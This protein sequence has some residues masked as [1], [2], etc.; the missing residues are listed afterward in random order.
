[1]KTVK[2]LVLLS[3]LMLFLT[4]NTYGWSRTEIQWLRG[5]I[6]FPSNDDT[7]K[8]S[9]I[10]LTGT[11]GGEGWGTFFFI[12]HASYNYDNKS[13]DNTEFVSKFWANYSLSALT[14][15]ELKFG[16][17]KDIR[18]VAGLKHAPEVDSVWFMPG[19]QLDLNLPGFSFAN[20]RIAGYQHISGGRLAAKHFTTLD[21]E[22][23]Y[24]VN[25]VWR[26]PFMIGASK[27]SVEGFAEWVKG[28]KQIS[29]FGSKERSSWLFIQP[30]IRMDFGPM[31]GLPDDKLFV[32][33]E[34]QYWQNK[35]GN[36]LIDESA[37]QLLIAYHF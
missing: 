6:Q 3:S 25:F 29:N 28:S 31:I 30:Q 37:P 24:Q 22:N 27:W 11:A 1:M 10:T 12:D 34:Y 23:S 14:E 2:N 33:I 7:V 5:D 8:T 20:V 17:I 36:P 26:Y 16:M 13:G 21:E 18:L 15:R 4:A 32:G 19:I 9:V 35:L